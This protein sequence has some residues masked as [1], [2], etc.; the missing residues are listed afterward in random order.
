[1]WGRMQELFK[2]PHNFGGLLLFMMLRIYI[3]EMKKKKLR[4]RYKTAN[5]F[6]VEKNSAVSDSDMSDYL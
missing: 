4:P 2:N 5:A 3:L 6:F 1:F